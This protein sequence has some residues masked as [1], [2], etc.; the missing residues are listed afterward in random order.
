MSGRL[1]IDL[2]TLES[3][4]SSTQDEIVIEITGL[5]S[6]NK[7]IGL[8]DTPIYYDNG[9]FFKVQDSKIVYTDITWEDIKG[10][11]HDNPEV[12]N[13]I[14][15]LVEETS[16]TYTIRIVD[17]A[18]SVHNNNEEAHPYIQQTIENNYQTLNNKIDLNK[19]E[20]DEEIKEVNERLDTNDKQIEDLQS[21]TNDIR[22][23]L[24]DLTVEVE[25]DIKNSITTL[26]EKVDGINVN[27]TKQ[28]DDLE[29][30]VNDKYNELVRDIDDLTDV[31][32]E[33]YAK[34]NTKIDTTAQTINTRITDV[35]DELQQSIEENVVALQQEDTALQNQINT[36]S[37]TLT[38]YDTRITNNAN[39]IGQEIIDRQNA[40]DA[41]SDRIDAVESRGRFLALW[42]ATTGLPESTPQITPYTYKTGD[43]YIVDAVGEV[44]YRPTGT[45][46]VEGQPS[47]EIE[48][49][50]LTTDDVYYYDGA[51]WRLQVN[52]GKTVSFG[53][54]TGQPSDNTA[55]KQVLD[56]KQ[57][58]LIQGKNI[59]IDSETNIISAIGGISVTYNK[60]NKRMILRE[61][62]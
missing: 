58:K 14:E 52:H 61:D 4:L 44:N 56:S 40:D 36:H 25:V 55:L 46:F 11:I 42:N 41:L 15:K 2:Y 59:N 37:Q 57:N 26:D 60:D 1:D 8:E 16:K 31:V 22:S 30:D 3:D 20:T 29:Q 34:L 23:D 53:N 27:L 7:F 54:L 21:F 9:K 18:I 39:A 62:N 24:D 6:I 50:E 47:T 48:T 13:E 33:D 43:Y 32:E 51:V 17:E 49:E 12:I 10:N 38:A 45:E 5:K 19:L 28:I 35:A